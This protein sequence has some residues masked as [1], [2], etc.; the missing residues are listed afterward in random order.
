MVHSMAN[1]IPVILRLVR[2]SLNSCAGVKNI[3]IVKLPAATWVR[4]SLTSSWH[5]CETGFS[6]YRYRP[7]LHRLGLP[8]R[9]SL[10]PLH[11]VRPPVQRPRRRPRLLQ[12]QDSSMFL[13]RGT[14]WWFTLHLNPC[15]A[16]IFDRLV[17]QHRLTF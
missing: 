9:H 17:P 14:S 5:Y 2:V 10:E 8:A 6:K 12:L 16:L 13:I 3:N 4:N 7:D 1:H 15:E 11:D